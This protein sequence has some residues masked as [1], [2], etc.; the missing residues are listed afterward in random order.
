MTTSCSNR[1]KHPSTI[2]QTFL[3]THKGTMTKTYHRICLTT[4]PTLT[5]CTK[6]STCLGICLP[7][8][9]GIMSMIRYPSVAKKIQIPSLCI[10][11]ATGV[12]STWRSNTRRYSFQGTSPTSLKNSSSLEKSNKPLCYL[13][14]ALL[15]LCFTQPAAEQRRC[16]SGHQDGTNMRS[17]KDST[18]ISGSLWRISQQQCFLG[19]WKTYG[20]RSREW[21]L[22][23]W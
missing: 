20:R 19:C 23:T 1:I 6:M 10:W 11:Q 9:A 15:A 12:I 4:Q 13:T 16:Y 2:R 22:W 8:V 3:P 18:S 17:H 21:R 7:S 5:S 14:H